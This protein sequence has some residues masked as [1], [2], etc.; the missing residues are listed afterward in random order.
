LLPH[1]EVGQVTVL[2]FQIGEVTGLY[3]RVLKT[4]SH[5]SETEAA[6]KKDVVT[7]SA[8]AKRA[9]VLEEAQSAVLARIKHR[10]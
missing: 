1:R 8:E 5:T 10:G 7:I 4:R 3:Q 2:P 9:K 6:E